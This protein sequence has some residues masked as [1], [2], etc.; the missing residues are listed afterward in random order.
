MPV[1]PL[2]PFL[3]YKQSEFRIGGNP[4]EV[5]EFA[6]RWRVFAENA[7]TTAASLRA[8]NDGGFLGDEGD[9]YREL[10]HGEFPNHLTITGE[11]HRGVSTAVAQYAEALT[12]AQTQMNALIVVALVD[13]TAVQ[14]AVANYNLCEANVV[15]AAATAK[16]ATATAVA[17]AALPGVNAITAS[18]ATAAQSELAAAQAAFEAAK[19]EHLRA[20]T[21]FDAD[22]AK[23]AGI[24]STLSMEVD[25]AVAW[26]KTQARRRFEEN[27]SWLQEKWEAFKDWVTKHSKEISDISDALQLIGGL[28]ALFPPLAPLGVFL[29]FVGVALKGLLWLT[30]NC[31][32][33]EFGFDL[34]TCLPGG[35]ILKALKGTRPG[36]ALSK[37]AKAAKAKAGK[38]GAKLLSRGNKCKHPGLEPVDMATGAMIDFTTDIHIDGMLPMVVARNTDSG[39]DTSRVFGPGWNTTLDC[40]I[41]ILPDQVLMMTP[42]GALLEFPPAP[43]DGTEVG[44][45]GS[46]WR[47]CF[48]DGAYRVRN[49]S[50]GVTYVFGVAGSEAQGGMPCY[51]PEGPVPDHTITGDAPKN[52]VYRLDEETGELTRRERTIEDVS[53]DDVVDEDHHDSEAGCDHG[54]VSENHPA[55]DASTRDDVVS[56]AHASAATVSDSAV[57]QNSPDKDQANTDNPQSGAANPQDDSGNNADDPGVWEASNSFVNMLSPGSVADTF[58]LGVEVQLS[59]MVHHSGAWIEYNY[60]QETG[61]LVTMRRSD[62]TVLELKWHN[63]ISRLLSIWVKNEET[64]PGEEPFRLASYNYDGKGRL[65]K[66]INS[67]AGALRYFY[68]DQHRPFRWTDRNGHSY[69]YRFDDKGRVVAQVGS[70]G[71]FP[72]V[73]VWLPDEGDDAPEDGM[74]CVA[75]ECAGKFHGN[76]TEIGDSCI[77]E[78]FD[79]LDK[80]P[81]AN[82]LREKGL[83]GAG[84]TGRGRTSTRDDKQ[85]A[86]PEE[87]LRD[88]FLGD[89]RPTVYR[90]TPTGD[91]WRIITPEGVVTDREY[92]EHHQIIRETSNTGVVTTIGR[93]EYG[94]ITRID[95]GDGTTETITPGAWG[96]P[97]RVTGRDG[98]I[99]EYEVDAAGMVTAVTDPLGVV[100]RFEYDWRA[101]GI[102]PKATITPNGLTHTTECDNAGRPIASTDPAGRR[103]S[104]T[105]DV[106]GLVTEVID[107]VGNVTTIEYSPEGWVTRVVNPDGSER[108]GT[109][110]GEGNLTQT[111]NEAGA[112]TTTRYT[113]FDQVNEVIAPNGG[114]TCYTYN[115]QME[116]IMV[117]N[118]DGHTWQL[119]YDLDGSIIKEIDYNGLVTES[120]ATPDGQRLDTTNGMGRVTTMFDPYGRMTET[121]DDQGNATAYQWDALGRIRQVTNQWCTTDYSYDEYGRSLTETTTL[122]SGESHTMAFSYG[123]LGGVEMIT[124]TLPDGKQVS[125]TPLFDEEGVLRNSTY[126]LGNTEVASLSFGVDDTGRRSWAHVGSLVRSFDYDRNHRLVR[127]QVHALTPGNNSSNNSHGV[128]PVNTATGLND[129]GSVGSSQ[130][131]DEYHAVGVIDR[132]FIWRADDVITQIT[133]QIRGVETSYDV[134]PMGRVTRVIHQHASGNTSQGD[135][136][137]ASSQA[138]YSPASSSQPS[139]LHQFQSGGEESYSYST[140]G[141]LTKLHPDMTKRWA[142]DV[143]IYGGTMPRQ[144]GRTKFTYDKAGRVTQTVTKR[145]SKKPLVKHFYYDNG[146]QPVGYE[147]SDHPGVGWRYL[148]DGVRRRVGK[149][150]INTTTGEVTSRVMFLHEGDVLFGEYYT[151]NTMNPQAVGS[152]RLWPTDPGTGEILG[153][154][155]I[156]TNTTDSVTSHGGG[157]G[158]HGYGGVMGADNS[159][160]YPYNQHNSTHNGGYSDSPYHRD[161]SATG[162]GAG[163]VLGWP[164]QRVDAVFY[165]MVCDLA[166]APKELI[167]PT[168]GEIVGY[169]TYTLFGKRHW[170]GTVNTPLLFTGQYE[171]TESGWVYNRFRYYDPHAGVY[172]AQDPLG[173][174]ANLGTA[175]GYVTNPIT[176]VDV[177]GLK[178]CNPKAPKSD[179][180]LRVEAYKVQ[181]EKDVSPFREHLT[182]IKL[183]EEG[184]PAISELLKKTKDPL[185]KVINDIVKRVDPAIKTRDIT[186]AIAR[187]E[188]TFTDGSKA[189]KWVA[190][191]SGKHGDGISDYFK[192]L[193]PEN[194]DVIHF[195]TLSMTGNS[196]A[197]AEESIISHL[198]WGKITGDYSF[199]ND[200]VTDVVLKDVAASR[201]VCDSCAGKIKVLDGVM[202]DKLGSMA[203]ARRLELYEVEKIAVDIDKAK[204]VRNRFEAVDVPTPLKLLLEDFVEGHPGVNP[205]DYIK[206]T[207]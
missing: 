30:G 137:G 19:A 1:L 27:P 136:V 39:M 99:T 72:N 49:I 144:V 66:V 172:N 16:V 74:V 194:E 207:L 117:T 79:R 50:E 68:D 105:R 145:L 55:S 132:V 28:L 193:L 192:H 32:W 204:L 41:E 54:D 12:S 143:D 141:V 159:A 170:A 56:N 69:H 51:R 36:K 202:V 125:E 2:K 123:Q 65:L 91:V 84:L 114:I 162:D 140:A 156:N 87:L 85:W 148:Y 18:T 62:G 88:E 116:P 176:W 58:N 147:D 89:I 9:R 6:R 118:A 122:Y 47:L 37:A 199:I 104:V 187:V 146:T 121:F 106:R 3:A 115:T 92:D 71:M 173:L 14:T 153:Q 52:Y 180:E 5:F 130:H 101:T 86:L 67:A 45:K 157:N 61:H 60:E 11:A 195:R 76:P 102:V 4:A 206:T 174:L 161:D 7:L 35:K 43:V 178:G 10:I 15:R 201:Y 126:T 103:S 160:D 186:L 190:A 83:Q 124:H 81:L 75:L 90:S 82:L 168:T 44:D 38:H 196:T 42:D 80:L 22:V 167:D 152:A 177:L 34:I 77:S 29:E 109:Y 31:S 59:T 200:N 142:D 96:E 113:V 93:D 40:R 8:I 184:K 150:Q 135:R 73:A 110:D 129:A 205:W 25:T 108:S 155:T 139:Q 111:V 188:V 149:E 98:L 198:V 100:T 175:Q 97:A 165:S 134:D 131:Q 127:D 33:Q 185:Q 21:V 70:G 179:R 171:D 64:H 183:V 191:T 23:G 26:I 163:G 95:F 133:D 151:V 94:T 119:H 63:R 189:F 182:D 181:K 158:H 197:H 13:H 53:H 48:V 46:P 20:T 203:E 24:K 166:G 17:T 154:I 164:Q 78:Y 107:P 57:S 120:H 169:A 112:I 138:Q 128:G